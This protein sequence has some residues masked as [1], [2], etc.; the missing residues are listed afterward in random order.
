[1]Q[2]DTFETKSHWSSRLSPIKQLEALRNAD[3]P[4]NFCIFDNLRYFKP[5]DIAI[6]RD[7]LE[8]FP[9]KVEVIHFAFEEE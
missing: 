7:E 8:D 3:K 9:Y 5:K 2:K 1:V 4:T 6:L